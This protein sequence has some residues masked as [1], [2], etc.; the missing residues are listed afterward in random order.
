MTETLGKGRHH[1]DCVH[2]SAHGRRSGRATPTP[3]ER[4]G[5]ST[6]APGGKSGGASPGGG[7]GHPQESGR[8]KYFFETERKMGREICIDR[9]TL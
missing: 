9:D 3:W 8:G 2:I 6:P 5:G 4:S 1:V 7:Q